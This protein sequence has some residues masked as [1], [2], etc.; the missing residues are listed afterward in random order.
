MSARGISDA[1]ESKIEEH[2]KNTHYLYDAVQH[3]P[4]RG[5]RKEYQIL[6]WVTLWFGGQQ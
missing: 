5:S 2:V 4:P 6:V 1:V 3:W